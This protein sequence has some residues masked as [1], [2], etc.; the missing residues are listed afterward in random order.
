MDSTTVVA[1]AEG[2]MTKKNFASWDE[3]WHPRFRSL[4]SPRGKMR[5]NSEILRGTGTCLEVVQ[6]TRH[7]K[8]TATVMAWTN[9]RQGLASN[10]T[11]VFVGHHTFFRQNNSRINQSPPGPNLRIHT[12]KTLEERV[13]V[14]SSIWTHDAYAIP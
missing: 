6:S 7:E 10:D 3:A 14:G 13:L 8:K 1:K 5:S 9:P 12:L 4:L 11:D 2:N